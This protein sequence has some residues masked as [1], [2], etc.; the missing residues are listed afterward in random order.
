M[1]EATG[2]AVAAAMESPEAGGAAGTAR[3]AGVDVVRGLAMVLMAIDHVRVFSGLPAGG[4][5]PGIFLTRWVTHFCAPA[6]VFLAGA[7]AFL[8]GRRH[9]DLSRFLFTRGVWLIF[10]ELTWCRLAWTF[11]LDF[12]GYEMA[13]VLWAIG[14]SLIVLAALAKLPLAVTA[15]FGA[16]VVG[17]HNLFDPFLGGRMAELAE[18][19][20]AAL[21]KILYLSFYAGPIVA[22][23]PG[24]DGPRLVVLYSLV[25]WIGVMAL[26]YLF[27][28]VLV[29]EPGRRD[30]LCLRL[31]LAAIAAFAMLRGFNLY[32]D[33]FPWQAPDFAAAAAAGS[34]P[35][36]AWMALLNATKYPASLDFL[37]MTLGPTLALMPL[38]GRLRGGLARAVALFGRV[39]MFFYLLHIPLIHLLAIGVSQL[40]LGTVSPWLF[41]NH[42][43]GAPPVPDGYTWS[44]PLLYAVWALAVLLLY[45]PCRWFAGLKARRSDPWLSY[46]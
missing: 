17:G 22:G 32:G 15:T 25:P 41:A 9:P 6:F 11:N 19:R 12:R 4:A 1:S 28:Q 40:R 34:P 38:L 42:P 46:F 2:A 13:G 14:W 31:G 45:F 10:L 33:P 30:R 5:T 20:F 18:S 23:P 44:L 27:G 43:M 36:P 21:W 7:S 16:L 35:R 39:P 26:G 29:M 37:L 24:S 3:N 8:Y